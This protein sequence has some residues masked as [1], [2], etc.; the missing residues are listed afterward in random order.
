MGVPIDDTGAVTED[1]GVVGGLI[2]TSGDID[3]WL[4]D[5]T[6]EWTAETISGSYGSS[7]TIDADGVWSYTA[8]NDHAAIDALND[9]ETLTEV[10]TVTSANGTATITI[11]INGATDPPCFVQGTLIETL[12]GPRS[13][14]TLRP[15]DLIRTRDSGLQALSWIGGTRISLSDPVMAHA[16]QPVRIRAGAFGAGVPERDLLVSPLHRVLVTHRDVPLLFGDTEVLCAAQSLVNG[17]SIVRENLS[18]VSYFHMMFDTH[19]VVTSNGC[20]SESFYPGNVAMNRL[21]EA[22][23]EELFTLFPDLRSLPQSFGRTARMVLKDYE[24]R[25]IRDRFSL[26][27]EQKQAVQTGTEMHWAKQSGWIR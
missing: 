11:I 9:G 21:D 10:F 2:G 23:R 12:F 4:T 26:E 16:F 7:L 13:V 18:S 15:G 27:Y 25:L 5:D 3:Y 14:E 1:D 8:L 22:Q 19:Q 20:D 17:F 24:A 6:G